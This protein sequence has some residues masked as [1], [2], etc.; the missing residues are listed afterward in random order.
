MRQRSQSRPLRD[1]VS[2]WFAV[3]GRGQTDWK[4]AVID[5]VS[6]K[7]IASIPIGQT[8][9]ALVYVPNAA[10]N[11]SGAEN[12]SPLGE[13][14][15]TARLHLQAVGSTLPNAQ[16][17]VAV[18]SLGLVDLPQIAAQGLTPKSQY[19][20]YLAESDHA[21]F[22]RLEPLA[23]LR[24]NADGAGIVQTVGPLKSVSAGTA[25]DAAMGSRRFLVVTELS[26]PS[27]VILQQFDATFRGFEQQV[28]PEL[29]RRGI[30][31]LGMK[32]LGGDSQPI[33]Y[34]VVRAEEALRY[35]M[36]LPVA[37]TICGIDSLDVLQQNVGVARGFQPMS[38]EECK[39]SV[40]DAGFLPGMVI[41]NY[42][43]TTKKY[44]GRVGREQHGY[45]P[46]EQ[47][48]L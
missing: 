47:L 8:T 21:P 29:Q 16:A 3:T 12:L 11:G 39:R 10:P 17:S 32:S 5:T 28:L 7:V 45:P 14:A 26:D 4:A 1:S 33:Q 2:P 9:Q 44:D 25:T 40:S 19:Q 34:G 48:P 24:T 35:A 43:K 15:N 42:S 30:A 27:R 41:S 37:T 20:L 38:P 6:N 36:S 22:G 18:N 23:I 13:A 31:A 46:P